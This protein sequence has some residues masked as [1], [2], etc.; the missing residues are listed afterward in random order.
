MVSDVFRRRLVKAAAGKYNGEVFEDL[1]DQV[2]EHMMKAQAEFKEF[3]HKN[4]AKS[5]GVGACKASDIPAAAKPATT[6]AA[7]PAKTAAAE[8]AKKAAD[9]KGEVHKL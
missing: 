7:E 1:T 3:M 2:K 9:A 6:A 5:C 8:P 4:C